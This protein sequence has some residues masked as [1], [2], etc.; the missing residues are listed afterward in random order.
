M[1]TVFVYNGIIVFLF[2]MNNFLIKSLGCEEM[3]GKQIL[4]IFGLK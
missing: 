3:V 4:M 1:V 2:L